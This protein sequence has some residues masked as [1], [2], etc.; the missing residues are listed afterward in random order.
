MTNVQRE[1]REVFDRVG[2]V[3]E[4][5][6]Y[7][8]KYLKAVVK[9]TLRLHPPGTLLLPRECIE[10]CE[11]NGFEIPKNT[12]VIVNAWAIGR[13]PKYWSQ[14]EN[15]IPERFL[16]S[17]VRI[18]YGGNDFCYIPFGAG[19]RICPGISFGMVT[20][21]F[22]LALLLYHFDWKHPNRIIKSENLDMTEEFGV[23]VRRKN[24]TKLI[25]IAY[26]P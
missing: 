2:K 14:P 7:Q 18:D 4:T 10:S 15:F 1:V 12:R 24:H 22:S 19:R 25:P 6:I 17:E 23:T 5:S 16:Q 11:I 8:M 26:H 21:E 13:D 3:D 20:V 9:E